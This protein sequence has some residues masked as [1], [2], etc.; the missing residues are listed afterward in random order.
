VPQASTS[1]P[2]TGKEDHPV[3]PSRL[4]DVCVAMLTEL[5]SGALPPENGDRVVILR[6]ALRRLLETGESPVRYWLHHADLLLRKEVED[7]GGRGYTR[8]ALR[9]LVA[10]LERDLAGVRE[11]RAR[12]RMSQLFLRYWP[13]L[14][15]LVAGPMSS[16][17][18]VGSG[19]LENEDSVSECLA[20]LQ[21]V[22]LVELTGSE[23]S[24]VADLTAQA[25]CLLRNPA[26]LTL[27]PRPPITAR[28]LGTNHD[29]SVPETRLAAGFGGARAQLRAFY[30]TPALAIR[31]DEEF[32][33]ASFASDTTLM[34]R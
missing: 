22:G 25:V 21:V 28:S 3:F 24:L 26:Q 31:F 13:V 11:Q 30:E 8:T 10:E 33:L 20:K 6:H 2:K 12:E 32:D 23:Q 4:V 27:S 9:G 19:G 16:R 34:K 18:L 29:E 5:M 17:Q 7:V 1:M 14:E 15:A